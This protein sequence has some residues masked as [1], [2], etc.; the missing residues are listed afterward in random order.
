MGLKRLR[1]LGGSRYIERERCSHCQRPQ[2]RRAPRSLARTHRRLSIKLEPRAMRGAR[3]AHH[4]GLHPGGSGTIF[5][6]GSELDLAPPRADDRR[7]TLSACA[8]LC[9]RVGEVTGMPTAEVS[10]GRALLGCHAFKCFRDT[11]SVKWP[12]IAKDRRWGD[13]STAGKFCI[14]IERRRVLSTSVD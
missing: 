14:A 7:R 11:P 6:D 10:A 5:W 9:G 13:A 2:P 1:R 3:A 12:R 8:P 4:R